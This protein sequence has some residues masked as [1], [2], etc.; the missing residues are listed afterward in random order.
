MGAAKNTTLLAVSIQ[1]SQQFV[2]GQPVIPTVKH[3]QLQ[4]KAALLG[5]LDHVLKVVILTQ[6]IPDLYVSG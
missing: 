4:F 2:I 3:Y 6:T 1:T 5:L